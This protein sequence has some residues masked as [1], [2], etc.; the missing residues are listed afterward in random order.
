[1][2]PEFQQKCK[3][4]RIALPSKFNVAKLVKQEAKLEA[5]AA[6]QL[7]ITEQK[8]TAQLEKEKLEE[9]N[10]VQTPRGNA[11]TDENSNEKGTRLSTGMKTPKTSLSVIRT[12][13]Q[14]TGSTS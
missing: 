4:L 9:L 6:A 14:L 1:M 11:S 5:A 12:A 8:K 10:D 13:R 2:M 7:K 3:L